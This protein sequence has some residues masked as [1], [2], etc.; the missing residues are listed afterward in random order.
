MNVADER[1]LKAFIRWMK[2]GPDKMQPAF[3]RAVDM[4][5]APLEAVGFR[6]ADKAF[7]ASGVP[8]HTINLERKATADSTDYVMVIFD[9]H[10]R[11]R[12]QVIFGSKRT[13]PPQSWIRS[14]ALV[15]KRDSELVKYKWWGAKW[16]HL[17]KVKSLDH[18]VDRVMTLMPQVVHYLSSG[19][20][21]DNVHSEEIRRQNS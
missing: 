12:F 7:D 10:R 11:P 5:C 3:L 21:G 20:A 17:N 4:F 15:W 8:A 18:A 16:W 2:N 13:M 9:N 19:E 6:C 1:K 14:A